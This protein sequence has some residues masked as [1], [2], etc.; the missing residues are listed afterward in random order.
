LYLAS[1]LIFKKVDDFYLVLNP[2]A[3]NLMVIDSSGKEIMEFCDGKTM[4]EVES[5]IRKKFDYE[6]EDVKSFLESLI[7]SGFANFGEPPKF[8]K[9]RTSLPKSL[10]VHLT[11]ACNLRC[12]HCYFYSGVPLEDELSDDEFLNLAREF[13]DLEIKS[14]SI[15]G[16]EPFLRKELLFKFIKE[17]KRQEVERITMST[18]GTL[19]TK[20]DALFLS[21]YDVSVGVSLDG[22]T[23]EINDYIRGKGVFKKAVRAIK[24]LVTAGV[25]TTIGVTL[26]KPNITKIKEMMYLAKELDTG[27][28][29]NTVRIEGRA[30]QYKEELSVSPKEEINAL[31]EA[32]RLSRELGVRTTVEQLW[33]SLKELKPKELCG[34]GRLSLC[35][36]SNGDVYPCDALYGV[37]ALK[38][39]NLRERPL[40]EIWE[41]SSVLKKFHNLSLDKIDGCKDCELKYICGG[42]CLADNYLF[43][44]SF[45]KASPLQCK[46]FKEVYWYM[47]CELARE[48]WKSYNE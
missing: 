44:G 35:V 32:W 18:N 30:R 11:Q 3:P 31:K 22:P 46:V 28:Y 27:V 33:L 40:R 34:A 14:L 25:Q 10:I 5:Y 23:E 9:T 8:T 20:E 16:G 15:T 13:K 39:G 48:M 26:M 43:T 6:K 47:L 36:A 12:K 45:L 19:I 42:G 4:D 2:E 1:N 37:E 29:L 38:A 17:A 7:A 21:E 24:T 41:K